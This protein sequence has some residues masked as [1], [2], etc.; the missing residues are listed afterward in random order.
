MSWFGGVR[1]Q[2]GFTMVEM[3]TVIS[4]VAI[5]SMIVIVSTQV[6]NQRQQLRDAA[7]NYISAARNAESLANSGQV[8]EGAARKAYGVCITSSE[9]SNSKCGTPGGNQV[10]DTYQVFARVTTEATKASLGSPPAGPPYIVASFTLPKD[11]VFSEP[12]SYL[13]YVPPGPTLYANGSQADIEIV[14]RHKDVTNCA[15]SKDCQTIQIKPRAGAIYVA[16]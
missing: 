2:R 3:V 8:F 4:I 13:D 12:A 7:A 6:G 11:F 16:D 15:G 14:I 5:L 10:L 1:S 9:I